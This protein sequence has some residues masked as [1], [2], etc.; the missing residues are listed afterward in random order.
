MPILISHRGLFNGPDVSTENTY[1]QIYTAL[2]LGYEVETDVRFID[3]QWWIGHDYPQWK[4]DENFLKTNNL[5]LHAKN[6]EA[7]RRLIDLGTNC[8]WHQSDD[9]TV[10]NHGF[11]WA[12]PGKERSC[13]KTIMVMPEWI[14]KTLD[15]CKNIDCYGICSDYVGMLTL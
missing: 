14:D 1:H 5:W 8:F 3:D 11:I 10:T 15:H 6:V 9:Y 2:D 12:Y 4:T 7:L 13:P